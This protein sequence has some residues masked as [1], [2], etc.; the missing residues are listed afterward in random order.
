MSIYRKFIHFWLMSKA[1]RRLGDAL[2]GQKSWKKGKKYKRELLKSP[3]KS[4]QKYPSSRRNH[5]ET[6]LSPSFPLLAKHGSN[7]QHLLNKKNT[8]S[9][10]QT[11]S[12]AC[13]F[14]SFLRKK[15]GKNTGISLMIETQRRPVPWSSALVPLRC[16]LQNKSL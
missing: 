11:L 2:W 5:L 6:S 10:V 16:P 4:I 3:C 7:L 1:D 13:N 8:M 9:Y 15:K 14:S 12:F